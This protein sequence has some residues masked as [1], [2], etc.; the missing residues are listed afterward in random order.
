MKLIVRPRVV[1][2]DEAK[3]IAR[4]AGGRLLEPKEALRWAKNEEL[5]VDFWLDH[6]NYGAPE[7][8]QYYDA[9]KGDILY[10][11]RQNP[12]LLVYLVDLKVKSKWI[13][14]FAPMAEKQKSKKRADQYE[15]KFAI[16]G[17]LDEV[18]QASVSKDKPKRRGNGRKKW[19]GSGES[20]TEVI[21]VS[22]VH[23]IGQSAAIKF[24][25]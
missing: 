13:I 8:S 24:P 5:N 3:E 1:S 12:L 23:C 6:P 19:R 10:Q 4:K 21:S 20:N 11:P 2:W 15:E 7:Y 22:V 9:K 18:L 17:T 25:L 14:T 16:I